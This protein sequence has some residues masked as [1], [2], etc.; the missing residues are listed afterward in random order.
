M[1]V[2]QQNTGLDPSH[3]QAWPDVSAIG[4]GQLVRVTISKGLQ[5]CE[6]SD[7]GHVG[8]HKETYIR[9]I[10]EMQNQLGDLQLKINWLKK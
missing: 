10:R 6:G 5:G 1:E 7:R 4:D 3:Q 2:L 8:L 9:V